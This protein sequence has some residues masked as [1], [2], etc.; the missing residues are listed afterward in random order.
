MNQRMEA[1]WEYRPSSRQ[2]DSKKSQ[3]ESM[4]E[5]I[6]DCN[7]SELSKS[8]SRAAAQAKPTIIVNHMGKHHLQRDLVKRQTKEDDGQ[9]DESDTLQN[10][11]NQRRPASPMTVRMR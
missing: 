2:A 11:I 7:D 8:S 6:D 10:A 4:M 5:E 9:S 1:K 3:F